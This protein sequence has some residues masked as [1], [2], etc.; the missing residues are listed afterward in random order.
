MT[1]MPAGRDPVSLLTAEQA[2]Q[3]MYEMS[4]PMPLQV[5]S[6]RLPNRST[7]K[8]ADKAAAKLKI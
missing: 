1:T 5:N 4:I 7:R 3:M 6:T 2:V 8:A